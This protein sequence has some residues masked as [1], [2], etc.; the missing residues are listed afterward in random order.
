MPTSSSSSAT[1]DDRGLVDRFLRSGDEG[2][3]RALYRAHAP[4]L[5]AFALRLT[6]GNEAE[7]QDVLQ[8]MWL[9]ATPKLGDFRW[10]SSLRTWLHSVALNVHREQLRA[11]SRQDTRAAETRRR[12][13]VVGGGVDAAEVDLERGIHE[14]PDG[15]REVLLLHDVEG[16]TH[17]E[18]SVLLEIEEGTSKS[19]LSKARR[20]MRTWLDSQGVIRD[21]R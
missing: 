20:A 17:K 12:F 14:L 19:Q 21:A 2:A 18:I 15:Y 16:Y 7:A 11:R 4:A 10:Q 9:R 13:S 5:Y 6:R 1:A 8:D 3:F